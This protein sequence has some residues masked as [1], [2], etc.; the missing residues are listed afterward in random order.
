M[1]VVSCGLTS[2]PRCS[3][4]CPPSPTLHWPRHVPK[5]SGAHPD[6]DRAVGAG[7]QLEADLNDFRKVSPEPRRV[8]ALDC[9]FIWPLCSR[10]VCL[11]RLLISLVT[12][13]NHPGHLSPLYRPATR[14]CDRTRQA[15]RITLWGQALRESLQNLWALEEQEP[16]P[17]TAQSR[18]S[19]DPRQQKKN[20]VRRTRC[21]SRGW[22][23][24]CG[25]DPSMVAW[26]TYHGVSWSRS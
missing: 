23:Y 9:K 11:Q 18:A 5:A 16:D 10:P 26:K 17:Y 19:N 7:A 24:C 15:R 13:R 20:W 2:A 21:H 14:P 12:A 22:S 8:A 1:A 3:A 4:A 25:E 6:R